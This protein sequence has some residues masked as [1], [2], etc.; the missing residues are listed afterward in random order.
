MTLNPIL[1]YVQETLADITKAN[2]QLDW[3]PKIS[4][5]QG[6]ELIN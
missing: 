2:Q 6:I 3:Q 1:N 4:L 5:E